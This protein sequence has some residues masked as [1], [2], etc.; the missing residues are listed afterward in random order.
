MTSEWKKVSDLPE[1]ETDEIRDALIGPDCEI[2]DE[3]AEE[4]IRSQ[5]FDSG[6]MVD[7]FKGRLQARI[8]ENQE[9]GG[10]E[11]ENKNLLLFLRDITNYQRARSPENVKPKNWIDSIIDDTNKTLFPSFNTARSYRGLEHGDLPE[12]DQKLLDEAEADLE[13]PSDLD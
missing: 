5:G 4:I 6:T 12:N 9:A 11:T 10:K 8:R 13:N 7:E 3:T 2:D 1:I